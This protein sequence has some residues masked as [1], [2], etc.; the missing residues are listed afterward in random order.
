[1]GQDKLLRSY[2]EWQLGNLE[3][4]CSAINL[5]IKE[6]D[7]MGLIYVSATILGG[8]CQHNRQNY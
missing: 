7:K 8:T 1:M 5:K 3:L 4:G 6:L 2:Y